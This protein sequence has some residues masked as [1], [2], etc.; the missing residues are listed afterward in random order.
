MIKELLKE[1]VTEME[2]YSYF[3]SNKGIPEDDIEEIVER[4]LKYYE[5]NQ[6]ENAIYPTK[7]DA[8]LFEKHETNHGCAVKIDGLWHGYT[9]FNDGTPDF[10]DCDG[11]ESLE[12]CLKETRTRM[13]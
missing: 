6:F 3:G 9:L 2:D 11:F 5:F 7:D 8:N 1:Y 12:E 10:L 4:I 13:G